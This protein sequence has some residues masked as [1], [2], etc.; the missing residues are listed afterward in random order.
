M[1]G[2]YII[3]NSTRI[4][5]S[6]KINSSVIKKSGLNGQFSEWLESIDSPTLTCRV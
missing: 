5:L 2:A 4:F 1:S 6:L 3:S